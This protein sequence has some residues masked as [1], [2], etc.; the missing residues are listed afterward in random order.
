M[1]AR[2]HLT[3]LLT[4]RDLPEHKLSFAVRWCECWIAE[5]QWDRAVRDARPVVQADMAVG[6]YL[7]RH[8]DEAIS[9]LTAVIR[10]ARA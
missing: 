8:P 4:L 5:N 10:K 9:N 1:T 6:V 2:E 7:D 3:D